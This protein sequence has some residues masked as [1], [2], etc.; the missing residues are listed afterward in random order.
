MTNNLYLETDVRGLEHEI[1]R[2]VKDVLSY[3]GMTLT[4][5]VRIVARELSI[6]IT[7]KLYQIVKEYYD[8]YKGR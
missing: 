4:D 5:V 8:K 2:V 3:Y 1:A 7:D 6:A